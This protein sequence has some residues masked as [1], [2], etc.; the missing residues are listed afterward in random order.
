MQEC[1]ANSKV[2]VPESDRLATVEPQLARRKVSWVGK[3][4]Q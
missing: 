2:G 1:I 4:K 3:R